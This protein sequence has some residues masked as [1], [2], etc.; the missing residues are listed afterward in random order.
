[1][2]P[3]EEGIVSIFTIVPS[4]IFSMG[5]DEL[6]VLKEDEFRAIDVV[7]ST[8]IGFNRDIPALPFELLPVKVVYSSVKHPKH[9]PRSR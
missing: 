2:E 9:L 6:D 5:E 3:W 8:E 7:F 1:M 4:T